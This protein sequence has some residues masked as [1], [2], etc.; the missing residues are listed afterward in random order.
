MQSSSKQCRRC[1]LVRPRHPSRQSA[2]TAEVTRQ[3]I[4]V[5]RSFRLRF[6]RLGALSVSNQLTSSA[7]FY[8]RVTV[9][10]HLVR[11]RKDRTVS[12]R[13]GAKR[14]KT[15]TMA[16]VSLGLARKHRQFKRLC[17]HEMSSFQIALQTPTVLETRR[18]TASHSRILNTSR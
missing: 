10:L 18:L 15:F 7:P 5:H 13:G 1:R 4:P 11:Q 3:S 12:Q 17:T 8:C 2:A 6:D 14:I 16:S 9:L